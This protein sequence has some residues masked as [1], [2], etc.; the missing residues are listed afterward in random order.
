MPIYL[1]S[2]N[3]YQGKKISGEESSS[4]TQELAR[5]LHKRGYVLI[6]A[7]EKIEGGGSLQIPNPFKALFGVSLTDKLMFIR[8]LQVMISA[9]VPLPKALDVLSK[10]AQSSTFK[11]AIQDMQ[12]RIL[13]GAALSE[14]MEAHKTVFPELFTN[15]VKVGEESGTLEQVLSNLTVQLEHEHELRSK[16]TGALVYP[17]VILVAM[18][19]IGVLMLIFVVPT[20][21]KTFADLNVELPP[22]TRFVIG[23]GMFLSNFWYLAILLTLAVAWGGFLL[24]RTKQVKFIFDTWV[25][26]LPVFGG[27]VTKINSAFTVR[28]LSSLI[29]SGVPITRSLEITSHVLSNMHFQAALMDA[30]ERMKKGAKLSEVLKRYENLY[31][32]LVV[33]MIEVGEETGQTAEILQKLAEFFEEEVA[34]IT[35]NLA[36]ILEPILMLI[37]GAVVGFFAISMIQPMYSLL[38]SV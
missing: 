13:K 6:S 20:L 10:Q 22:T 7:K 37:I 3:S 28:T 33:Q 34:S 2:A 23:L 36:S 14:A 11:K 12:E 4:S 35:A 30:S 31:P 15:M 27:I 38:G 16:V 8:N 19:G 29:A 32:I 21:A 5:S 17:A 1:F 9:G 25:L 18:F 26:R 24:S